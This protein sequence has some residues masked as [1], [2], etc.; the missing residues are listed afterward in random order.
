MINDTLYWDLVED[1]DDGDRMPDRRYG[2]IVGFPNDNQ[3]Y[4]LD[5]VQLG[6][7]EDNDGFPDHQ[8]GWGS[9]T[10]F[11][12][13]VPDV[14][15]G[16]EHLHLRAGPEQQRRAGP[17]GGRRPGRLSI[18]SRPAGGSS[19][20]PVRPDPTAL[21]GRGTLFGERDRRSRSQQEHLWPGD[22]GHP[23][24]QQSSALLRGEQLQA[25]PGRHSRRV[26][27]HRRDSDPESGIQ[28]PR[29]HPVDVQQL[30]QLGGCRPAPAAAAVH[31]SVSYP[32]CA[33]I[34]TAGSTRP[35]WTC[36]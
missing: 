28:R 3:D 30:H 29:A 24:R 17:A 26:H 23:R 33:V 15:R 8:P 6:Q 22:T 14:R 4:D 36:G 10:R 21:G 25:R 5:G 32:T 9:D 27:R 20:R 1:N 19:V 34:R 35:T 16:A 13:A 7:D 31:L 2:N 12:R 11:R 18:R